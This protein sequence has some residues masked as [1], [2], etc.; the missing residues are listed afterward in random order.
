MLNISTVT[1][2]IENEE[3]L[4]I[5]WEDYDPFMKFNFEMYFFDIIEKINRSNIKKLILD[6]SRRKHDPSERDYKRYLRAFFKR[7][8]FY[9]T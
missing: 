6:C 8:I 5:R 7:F 4:Y 1:C 2:K 9:Q 3:I